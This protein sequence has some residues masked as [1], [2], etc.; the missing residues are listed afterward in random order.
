MLPTPEPGFRI[1][2]RHSV[3]AAARLRA[4][5]SN[6]E[7]CGKVPREVGVPLLGAAGHVRQHRFAASVVSPKNSI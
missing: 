3:V 6:P 7:L 4:A 5:R 2:F 1:G